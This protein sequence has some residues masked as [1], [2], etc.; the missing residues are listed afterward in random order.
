[1]KKVAIILVLLAA[2]FLGIQKVHASEISSQ[3]EILRNDPAYEEVRFLNNEVKQALSEVYHE[4]NGKP[5]ENEIEIDLGDAYKVY[6][7]DS[8]FAE[9][10]D[11][12]SVST[13][14]ADAPIVWYYETMIDD[15]L[16]LIEFSK[17]SAIDESIEWTEEE[18]AYLKAIEGKWHLSGYGYTL[19]NTPTYAEKLNQMTSTLVEDNP[20]YLL[21]GLKM[22]Q[23]P[24]ALI[25]RSDYPEALVPMEKMLIVD[26]SKNE[27]YNDKSQPNYKENLNPLAYKDDAYG[28]N[29]ID[30]KAMQQVA[31]SVEQTDRTYRAGV[32][33]LSDVSVEK[34]DEGT[35]SVLVISSILGLGVGGGLF[36]VLL[37]KRRLHES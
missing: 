10:N 6:L 2:M 3:V 37:R 18:Y 1:M 32:I 33:D 28:E 4:K 29:V 36:I 7:A 20:I 14:L 24:A 16:F 15:D 19:E 31:N 34:V 8:F 26:S 11:E 9:I 22:I 23:Y 27:V 5:I 13:Q 25:T 12:T 17:G 30:F 35:N 21:G